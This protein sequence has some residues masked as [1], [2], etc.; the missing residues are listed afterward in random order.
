MVER[1]TYNFFNR[2]M[3]F[4]EFLKEATEDDRK[5]FL[6]YYDKSAKK[7]SPES[8]RIDL[9]YPLNIL[10]MATV[11]CW[12]CQTN[13]PILTHIAEHSP[14]IN[15]KF[16]NK[17]HLPF[18]VTKVNNGEKIP[19]VLVYT[20]DFHYLDRWVERST[21]AY[22]LY[23]EYRKKYG[24]SEETTDQFVKEY[25]KAFL[26]HQTEIE[27]SVIEEMRTLFTRADAISGSTARLAEAEGS[28]D[29]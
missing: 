14:N 19:Q 17:D 26:K 12:D 11:W 4:E 8:F 10:V 23:A 16:M 21:R 5:R 28:C 18:M 15:M 20:E 6:Y 9:K 29:D 24:W 7:H 22:L 27:E 2:G 3:T 1:I 25:R 13:L